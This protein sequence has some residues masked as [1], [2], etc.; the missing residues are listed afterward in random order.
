MRILPVFLGRR[1]AN[2]IQE[3]GL[4]K[5]WWFILAA[6]IVILLFIFIF[7]AVIIMSIRTIIK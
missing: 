5:K 2:H 7:V 6:T 1:I 3:E 4:D